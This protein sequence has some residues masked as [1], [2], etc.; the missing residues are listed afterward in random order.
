MWSQRA[1]SNPETAQ[2]KHNLSEISDW[3]SEKCRKTCVL[4]SMNRKLRTNRS[5]LIWW[6]RISFVCTT[7]RRLCLQA[8]IGMRISNL[9]S[10]IRDLALSEA[11]IMWKSLWMIGRL[12]W[13]IQNC[14]WMCWQSAITPMI[15]WDYSDW[16]AFCQIWITKYTSKNCLSMRNR[17][18]IFIRIFYRFFPAWNRRNSG[19]LEFS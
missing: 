7:A 11:K 1:V 15:E 14:D 16:I 13:I 9:V 12:H 3:L 8:R 6:I 17:L 10:I 5:I 2:N 19:I 18:N 4:L